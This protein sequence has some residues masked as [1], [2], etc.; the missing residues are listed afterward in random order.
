MRG[1]QIWRG[2]DAERWGLAMQYIFV[3]TTLALMSIIVVTTANAQTTP[4]NAATEKLQREVLTRLQGT[5]FARALP[6]FS[7]G[8]LEGCLIEFGVL[9]QDWVYKQG[10]FIRVGGSF[11]LLGKPAALGAT[12]KVIVHD[13]DTR[14]MDYKPDPPVKASL[15]APD[16]TSNAADWVGGGKS[17]TPGALF[18]VFKPERTFQIIAEGIARSKV[19]IAF[20]RKKGGADV[21]VSVDPTIEDVKDG[22]P[23]RSLRAESEFLACTKKL[24]N[25]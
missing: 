20:S 4:S 17:D 6:S 1:N 15:L 24:I 8:Q 21:V 9:A 13:I 5:I 7:G 12:L 22:K 2:M 14:T 10:G 11:G 3:V 18:S 23:V 25:S 16:F 19:D